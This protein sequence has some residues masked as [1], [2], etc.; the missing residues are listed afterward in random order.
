MSKI[1]GIPAHVLFVIATIGS[2]VAL[3]IVVLIFTHTHMPVSCNPNDPD[4]DAYHFMV[5]VMVGTA[6]ISSAL[7]A[8]IGVSYLIKTG[9]LAKLFK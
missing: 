1:I 7:S 8:I 6:S 5:Q 4:Y 2:A 9:M 3:I